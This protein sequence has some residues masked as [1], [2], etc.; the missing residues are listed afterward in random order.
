MTAEHEHSFDLFG[1]RVRLLIAARAAEPLAARIAA[2]RVQ[3]RLTRLHHSL[4]RFDAA[5]ELSLL[6]QRAG[7]TVSISPILRQAIA[8]ALHAARISGGLVDPAV[9]P[10]LERAGYRTSRAGLAPAGLPAA[11]ASAPPRRA[12]KPDPAGAWQQIQLD[13]HSGTVRVPAGVRLDLGGSAKGMAVDIAARMLA[14]L[15]SFAVDAG[16]DIRLGGTEPAPAPFASST[17]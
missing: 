7:Q 5:S 17:H 13:A 15:P 16:G 8:A 11:I 6:N 2:L 4:T 1:T 9:L 12:A 3:A 10:H 14:P